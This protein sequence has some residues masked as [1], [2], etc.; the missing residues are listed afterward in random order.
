VLIAAADQVA[1]T[2]QG[3]IT[4]QAG[5]QKERQSIVAAA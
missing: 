2:V 5:E 1:T 4:G 3:Y